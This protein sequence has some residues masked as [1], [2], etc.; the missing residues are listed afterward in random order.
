M[1]G[2][3]ALWTQDTYQWG[4][5]RVGLQFTFIG[6]L[7]VITQLKI[8]PWAVKRWGD[9]TLLVNS[10]P[11]LG[12]GILLIPL[13]INPFY[14]FIPNMLLVFGNSLSNPTLQ[15]VVSEKISK[16]EY[17]GVLGLLQSAGSLGR[18]FGPLLGGELYLIVS[19][20]APYLVSGLILFA[21]YF[22]LQR[23]MPPPRHWFSRIIGK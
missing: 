9:H 16:E 15:A 4:P 6:I 23:Y 21:T 2:T 3:F 7:S 18:I 12:L 19:K 22:L 10:I 17:G 11:L 14:M 1:Q 8:L 13:A 5:E 20:D